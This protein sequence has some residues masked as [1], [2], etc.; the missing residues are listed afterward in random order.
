MNVRS[1]RDRQRTAPSVYSDGVRNHHHNYVDI[2]LTSL[3][4]GVENGRWLA[5]AGVI[6][7][8]LITAGVGV[9]E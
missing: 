1:V 9:E 8:T 3:V 6:A 5:R 2:K 7:A 4:V